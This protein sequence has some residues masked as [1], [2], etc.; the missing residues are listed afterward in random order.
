MIMYSGR[1]CTKSHIK[2]QGERRKWAFFIFLRNLFQSLPKSRFVWQRLY[3]W[4]PP[5][6]AV[7]N[8][9]SGYHSVLRTHF[10]LPFKLE[11]QGWTTFT[12]RNNEKKEQPPHLVYYLW[13]FFLFFSF[14]V[15][16]NK[17]SFTRR[18]EGWIS[19]RIHFFFFLKGKITII[20]KNNNQNK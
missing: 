6:S 3:S 17:T 1:N 9:S 10:V 20:K 4:M 11:T 2:P 12:T 13:F 7:A 8:S 16:K 14:W 18:A 5:S 15:E 19:G